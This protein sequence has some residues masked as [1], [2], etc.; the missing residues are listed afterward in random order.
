MTDRLGILVSSDRHLDYVVN[1]TKA[2]HAKGKAISLFFTGNGVL[3]IL[4]PQFKELV[5]KAELAVC[6]ISFRAYGLHGRENE[7]PG[8]DH[9][10]FATQARNA[11]MLSEAD[12]YLVF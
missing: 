9:M 10:D 1:I 4:A 6:D 8:V 11:E 12:R 2:A 7:V 3:L 5:G